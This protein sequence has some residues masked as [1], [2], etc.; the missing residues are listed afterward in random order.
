MNLGVPADLTSYVEAFHSFTAE[1]ERLHEEV[2]RQSRRRAG[3]VAD[4]HNQ[5]L[6]FATISQ[7]LGLS[8]ARIGQLL[9]AYRKPAPGESDEH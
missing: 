5:G 7:L 1:M 9:A 8:R 3:I 2:S 6:S 4:L